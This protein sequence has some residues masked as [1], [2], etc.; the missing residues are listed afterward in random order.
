MKRILSIIMVLAMMLSLAACSTNK[1]AETPDASPE[2]STVDTPDASQTPDAP[3]AP[4][5][6][7]TPAA[8][9]LAI[10]TDTVNSGTPYACESVADAI[11]ADEAVF[12]FAPAVMAVEPGLLN[13]FTEEITGFE[14]GAMFGP[15]IGS[16]PVIG[17][18]FQ[19]PEGDD[20][21]AFM[22][23]LKSK[24]D[25]RWNICTAAD[26]MVVEA[27]GNT[28]FFVMAPATFDVA[29]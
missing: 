27:I 7:E 17:Y 13:G 19:V 3:Q 20:V 23:S 16:I 22:D 4:V 14:E 8:Q 26:E 18:I 1:P 9:M 29:Q 11:V 24:A 5:D 10:F 2:Q 6:G 21:N 28:V 15:M 12:P 25:L